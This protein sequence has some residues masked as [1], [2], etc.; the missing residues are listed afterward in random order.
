MKAAEDAPASALAVLQWLLDAGLPQEVGQVVFGIPDEVSRQLLVDWCRHE[1][2]GEAARLA[3]RWG[4]PADA[5][6][7]DERDR[8][9]QAECERPPPGRP[10]AVRSHRSVPHQ[11][12]VP[13]EPRGTTRGYG[14]L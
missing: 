1:F 11:L 4:W 12:I 7:P 5:F 3:R 6:E 8:E 2:A 13:R 14:P 9:D 10:H